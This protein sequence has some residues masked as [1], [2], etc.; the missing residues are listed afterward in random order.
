MSVLL[1]VLAILLRAFFALAR[2]ALVNM[3]RARLVELEQQGV[4][5]ARALQ[6]LTDNSSQLL[7]TAE[8]GSTFSLVLAS[9]IAAIE[10]V[11]SV[12]Q[13]INQMEWAWVS[14]DLALG[15]AFVIVLFLTVMVLF[16]LGRLITEA[17]DVRK[18]E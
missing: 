11:P 14:H 5:S 8:I 15:V 13:W 10:F 4:T 6:N 9:S 3:R 7:A 2:S 17:V 1:F 12:A 18:P 16:I